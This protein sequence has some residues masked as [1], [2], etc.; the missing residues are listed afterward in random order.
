MEL[1][2][3]FDVDD[4][5]T[6]YAAYTH[7]DSSYLGTGDPVVDAAQGITP[8]NPVVG[9]PDNMFV[10]TVDW[11]SG[12]FNVG[13][14]TKYTDERPVSLDG[15]FVADDYWLTDAYVYVAGERLGEAFRGTSLRFVVNNLLDEDYLG[16]IAGGGA[17][18]G[19]PRTVALTAEARF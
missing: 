4:A 6:V 16:G 5:W 2:G 14:S 10:V 3:T 8:G 12:P 17:W 13:L 1:S 18:I 9:V 7:N 11:A 15:T 19:A